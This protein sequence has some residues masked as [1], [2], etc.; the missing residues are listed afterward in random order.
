MAN[1]PLIPT[2]FPFI[3]ELFAVAILK[4]AT[5]NSAASVMASVIHQRDYL[6]YVLRVL[7]ASADMRA[8]I[9][10]RAIANVTA[11]DSEG[12]KQLVCILTAFELLSPT[13]KANFILAF[14]TCATLAGQGPLNVTLD[15][16]WQP[17]R[18]P[19]LLE[20]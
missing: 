7:E 15:N 12:Q 20:P 14:K 1:A 8:A 5:T 13:K 17:G 16:T 4:R 19:P 2:P 10:D 11:S 9:R 3:G 6:A 18:I